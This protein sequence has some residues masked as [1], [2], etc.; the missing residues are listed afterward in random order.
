VNFVDGSLDQNGGEDAGYR[1]VGS[2]GVISLSG[3]GVGLSRR[4]R[5]KEPGF[6]I[7]SFPK[8][9][10][11]QFLKEYR[12]QY[13]PPEQAMRQ[14]TDEFYAPP[15]GYNDS[16]DHFK[17]FFTAIKSGTKV[18]EDATFGIR[19]AGPALL[20]NQSFYENR[21]MNWDPEAMKVTND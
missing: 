19:A 20:T 5:S 13:P 7:D 21:I 18:V 17:N 11:D 12:A 16:F 1:L 2:D 14:L 4:Q 3:R 8:A 10:Q 9:M 6:T 15:A